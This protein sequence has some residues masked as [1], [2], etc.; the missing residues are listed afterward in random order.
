MEIIYIYNVLH[1]SINYLYDKHK[2]HQ[3]V[4]VYYSYRISQEK[5]Y[6]QAFSYYKRTPEHLFYFV[7]LNKIKHQRF[8]LLSKSLESL[9]YLNLITKYKLK[10]NKTKAYYYERALDRLLQSTE[11]K[12]QKNTEKN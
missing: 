11:I 5:I 10:K 4:S 7:F 12:K 2:R 3:T 1:K 9:Y 8:N 6:R